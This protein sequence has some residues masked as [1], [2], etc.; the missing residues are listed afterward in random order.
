M[1]L[2]VDVAERGE[3]VLDVGACLAE[4]IEGVRED[5]KAERG[6]GCQ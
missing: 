1:A 4:L 6:P 5:V 3:D 2:G